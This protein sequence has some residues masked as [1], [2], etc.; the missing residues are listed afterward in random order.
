MRPCRQEPR[1]RAHARAQPSP[2]FGVDGV[3]IKTQ[4]LAIL[5]HLP[6][7]HKELGDMRLIGAREEKIEGIERHDRIAVKPI[8][9]K[10]ENVRRLADGQRA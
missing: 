2:Q 8:K 9:I 1:A 3:Q 10:H 4:Q 7:R 5:H 6:P